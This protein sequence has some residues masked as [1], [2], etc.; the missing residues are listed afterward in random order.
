MG[1][2]IKIN[3]A[4]KLDRSYITI[5]NTILEKNVRGYFGI[6]VESVS[7]SMNVGSLFRSAHAFGASFVFTVG[8]HYV[9]KM[10]EKAD[11]SETPNHVPFYRFPNPKSLVLPDGCDLIGIEFLDNAADLPSFRHPHR[12]AYILGP[13]RGSL[14]SAILERCVYT[15]KIPTKFCVNIGV[16]AAIAMYDR[17][18]TLGKFPLR[19]LRPGGPIEKRPTHRFGDPILRKNMEEFRSATPVAELEDYLSVVDGK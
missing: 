14:S 4:D 1:Q 16:A 9:R 2:I 10:G 17:S 18:I 12:A 19:P 3:V 6:G 13:E 11:T 15:V 5:T 8:A 7:K